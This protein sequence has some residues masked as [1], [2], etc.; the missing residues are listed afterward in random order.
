MMRRT[1]QNW[2]NS[3]DQKHT[4]SNTRSRSQIHDHLTLLQT[5]GSCDVECGDKEGGKVDV[6]GLLRLVGNGIVH[7]I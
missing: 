5:P 6:L 3:S 7:V 2:S 1:T 4:R